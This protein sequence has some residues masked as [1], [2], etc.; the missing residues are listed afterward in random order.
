MLPPAAAAACRQPGPHLDLPVVGQVEVG[1]VPLSLSNIPHSIEEVHSC[2]SSTAHHITCRAAKEAAVQAYMLSHTGAGVDMACAST[3]TANVLHNPCISI[4]LVSPATKF[5]ATK[6][7][8]MDLLSSD[9][10][11]AGRAVKYCGSS[12]TDTAGV[13]LQCGAGH[14]CSTQ[15]Q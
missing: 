10:C 8:L 3:A 5:L 12:S 13:S 15:A 4:G 11:Q 7:L 6:R 1:V 9:S 14:G 2:S